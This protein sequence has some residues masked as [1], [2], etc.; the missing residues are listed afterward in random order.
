MALYDLALH[1]GFMGFGPAT[2]KSVGVCLPVCKCMCCVCCE[3]LLHGG[4]DMVAPREG[5][6]ILCQIYTDIRRY[7]RTMYNITTKHVG[8]CISC[9]RVK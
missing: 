7:V 3:S 9:E 4:K 2:Q 8:I 1:I 6:A 5:L